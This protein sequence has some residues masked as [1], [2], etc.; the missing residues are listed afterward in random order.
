MGIEKGAGAR[1][2]SVRPDES[3][4]AHREQERVGAHRKKSIL[5]LPPPTAPFAS[6][7]TG[8]ECRLSRAFDTRF[9]HDSTLVRARAR[10]RDFLQQC[11]S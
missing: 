9:L 3:D 8:V 6:E 5:I 4:G 11:G 7:M 10:A 2:G 1:K